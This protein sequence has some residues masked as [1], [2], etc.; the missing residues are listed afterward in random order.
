MIGRSVYLAILA[1]SGASA[2]KSPSKIEVRS[3]AGSS[4]GSYYMN[5]NEV[6]CVSTEG[7]EL[8]QWEKTHDSVEDC[9][10]AHFEPQ[11]LIERCTEASMEWRRNLL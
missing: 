8:K 11:S 3:L 1:L 10:R 6:T 5:W 2:S 4:P 9:C 7:A